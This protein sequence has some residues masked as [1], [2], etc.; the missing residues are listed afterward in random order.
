MGPTVRSVFLRG[1][2]LG[3][4][5]IRFKVSFFSERHFLVRDGAKVGVLAAFEIKAEFLQQG[6]TFVK[7]HRRFKYLVE[8][9]YMGRVV[10]V[11]HPAIERFRRQKVGIPTD[12]D[13]RV[14]H[15][16][17]KVGKHAVVKQGLAL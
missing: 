6:F 11:V 12:S 8:K 15:T 13:I 9:F 4:E 5:S 7:A 2:F 1:E 17:D 14:M 10:K 16:L 3:L